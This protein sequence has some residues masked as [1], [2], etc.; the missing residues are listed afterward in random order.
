[1]RGRFGMVPEAFLRDER[2]NF[3]HWRVY[4]ALAIHADS[5]GICYPSRKILSD[6]ARIKKLTDIS[7]ITTDLQRRGWLEKKGNGGRS[8]SCTYKLTIPAEFQGAVPELAANGASIH[9]QTVPDSST[10]KERTINKNNIMRGKGK[11][12]PQLG[13]F[14][15]EFLKKYESDFP[16]LDIKFVLKKFLLHCQAS[17]K[18][19][20]NPHAAFEL[21]LAREHT[22]NSHQVGN[23]LKREW[24]GI[25]R[26]LEDVIAGSAEA[27]R[28]EA[29]QAE[30]QKEIE[31]EADENS[32]TQDQGSENPFFDSPFLDD[33]E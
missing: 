20:E 13:H 10:G 22:G 24:H 9:P 30:I 1:M 6:F 11:V 26:K 19:Y 3:V 12:S 18:K 14:S 32:H 2:L 28:L 15:N 8:K 5:D 33:W 23:D 21:W 27:D 17:G 29:R 16:E 4:A 31:A 25:E 7:N